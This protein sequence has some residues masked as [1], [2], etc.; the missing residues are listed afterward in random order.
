MKFNK[1]KCKVLHM[2][3]GNHKQK[4]RLGNEWFES[5]PEEKDLGVLVGGKPNTR[6]QCALTAQKANRVL[7]CIK[8]SVGSRAREGILPLYS[9]LVRPPCSAGSSSGAPDIRRTW[10]CWRG[11][12]GGHKHDQGAGAPPLWGQAGRVEGFSWRR[13]GSRETLE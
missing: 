8:R 12:R 10:T 5:S 7:G 4:Y 9:A 11:S 13:E 3:W 6:Q 2:G 1:A